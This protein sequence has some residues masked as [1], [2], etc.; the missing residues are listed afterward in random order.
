MIEVDLKDRTGKIVATFDVPGMAEEIQLNQ[1]IDFLV[2]L[3]ETRE[4]GANEPAVIARALAHVIGC[5][6]A[7]L[8][9]VNYGHPIEYDFAAE[10]V[11]GTTLGLYAWILKV[12]GEHK[13]RIR[14]SGEASFVHKQVR[15]SIPYG[16]IQGALEASQYSPLNTIEAIEAYEVKRLTTESIA[17]TGD[18]DGSKWFSQYIRL[19]AVFARKE[20]EE[21][22]LDDLE[23]S[24]F[25]ALR[26]AELQDICLPVALDIDFFLTS[27]LLRSNRQPGLIGSLTLPTLTTL[28]EVQKRPKVSGKVKTRQGRQ[29]GALGGGGF[30]SRQQKKAGSTNRG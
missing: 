15:Y 28:L 7:E 6:I 21:I 14:S 27:G 23:R 17:S 4:E 11:V 10:E 19:L 12:I 18:G 25:L 3:R 16:A 1:Y 30:R 20:G 22:P 26:A 24:N 8:R 9:R 5:D 13:P 2:T 29:V